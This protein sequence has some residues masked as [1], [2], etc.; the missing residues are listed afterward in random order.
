M[1]NFFGGQSVP[2]EK[3]FATLAVVQ[4]VN[5]LPQLIGRAVSVSIL[6]IIFYYYCSGS[7]NRIGYS[8]RL[9]YTKTRCCIAS[10]VRHSVVLLPDLLRVEV[11]L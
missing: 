9:L 2:Q 11:G 10:L 5:F 8:T 3:P 1:K 4:A 6:P 7:S